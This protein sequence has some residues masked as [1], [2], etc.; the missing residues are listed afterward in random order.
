M[1]SIRYYW[2]KYIQHYSPAS[3]PPSEA[4]LTPLGAGD[5]MSLGKFATDILRNP[6]MVASFQRMEEEIFRAWKTS[7]PA[8][9]E[10]REH[11]YYRMEGLSHLKMKLQGMVNNM[12]IEDKIEK[13]RKE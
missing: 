7:A 11:L 2:S 9:T 8:D 12:L 6:A 10:K 5:A 1:R 3:P 13:N 4:S